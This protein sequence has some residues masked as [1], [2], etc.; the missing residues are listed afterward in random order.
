M[1]LL[2]KSVNKSAGFPNL[3]GMKRILLLLA[4]FI[5]LRGY[6]PAQSYLPELKNPRFSAG[7]RA[8]NA[9]DSSRQ[10]FSDST[11]TGRPVTI[12]L[13]YPSEQPLLHNPL[14]FGKYWMDPERPADSLTAM[15]QLQTLIVQYGLTDSVQL[16]DQ[17]WQ[18]PTLAFQDAIP[19]PGLFPLL[20]VDGPGLY[21]HTDLA[22]WL[23]TQG[24][25]VV[26]CSHLPSR[27]G[28]RDR[29]S[30]TAVEYIAADL[31]FVCDELKKIPWIDTSR[32][33]A[34][35]W[36]MN[37][38]GALLWQMGEPAVRAIVSLDG[39]T[40]Y[41]YGRELYENAKGF[42]GKVSV[43]YLHFHGSLNPYQVP[44]DF[45]CFDALTQSDAYL[46]K[47]DGLNHYHFTS[48]A[49]RLNLLH[50]PNPL[51]TAGYRKV[52]MQTL[53]YLQQYLK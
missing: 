50:Q 29:F 24:F 10:Y 8:W 3:T 27:E 35:S 34:I 21:F 37:G 33:A 40:G 7:F 19:A 11:L 47:I 6:L 16:A 36:S 32:M 5:L 31:E 46:V 53:Q 49:N 2:H 22:E 41:Q 52:A 4:G 30:T 48:F 18:Q 43:P 44:K 45:H 38:V 25:A 26:A 12:F 1:T 39:A 17:L 23:A 28:V 42:S 51:F 14:P 15:L 20:V 9:I 13:W